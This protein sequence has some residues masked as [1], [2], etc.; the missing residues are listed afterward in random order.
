MKL[1]LFK[2][3]APA[4]LLVLGILL[5]ASFSLIII[6]KIPLINNLKNSTTNHAFDPDAEASSNVII[7]V[8]NQSY[9]NPTVSLTVYLDGRK[10]FRQSCETKDQHTGYYYYYDFTGTRTLKVTDGNGLEEEYSITASE[11]SPVWILISYGFNTMT[12]QFEL[13]ID[14]S[15]IP[16]R[17]E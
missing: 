13:T 14:S 4:L 5:V 6:F 10:L 1:F 11:D 15:S 8:T 7:M 17:W 16:F 3:K 12:D 2:H 9:E